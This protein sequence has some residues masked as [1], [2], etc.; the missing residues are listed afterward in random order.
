MVSNGKRMK[1]E[2]LRNFLHV[3]IYVPH[4]GEVTKRETKMATTILVMHPRGTHRTAPV[5]IVLMPILP[6]LQ[7]VVMEGELI[8]RP[9][10]D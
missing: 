5:S 8:S 4:K 1:L 7:P 6:E 2:E 10:P 9:L 3:E